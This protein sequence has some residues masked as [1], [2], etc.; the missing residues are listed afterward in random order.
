VLWKELGRDR[1]MRTSPASAFW[2]ELGVAITYELL[3]KEIEPFVRGLPKREN[4]LD[5]AQRQKSKR[6]ISGAGRLQPT[7][8]Q[9]QGGGTCLTW[10]VPKEG[11]AQEMPYQGLL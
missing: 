5:R 2:G 3:S 10:V 7:R 11:W 6:W 4:L 8:P 1:A 9:Q